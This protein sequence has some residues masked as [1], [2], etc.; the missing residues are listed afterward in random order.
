MILDR[1]VFGKVVVVAVVE[2]EVEPQVEV[3]EHLLL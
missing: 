2:V 3:E 1:D